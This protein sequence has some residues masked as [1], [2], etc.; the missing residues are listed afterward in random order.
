MPTIEVEVSVLEELGSDAHV[1]FTLNAPRIEAEEL[2]AAADE[3]E[4]GRIAENRTIW[5]ARVSA[6]T[7]AGRGGQIRLAVDPSAFYFFDPATSGNLLLG[8]H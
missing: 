2:R 8:R 6:K 5:N 4:A 1:I 3:E 7:H